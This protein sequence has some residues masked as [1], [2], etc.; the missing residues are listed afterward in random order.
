MKK[1]I[2][3]SAITGIL[4]GCGG[5]SGTL[6]ENVI[7]T[8]R[9]GASLTVIDAKTDAVKQTVAIPGSEPMYVVHVKQTDRLYVGDRAQNKVHV[10]HPST[11][12]IEASID[13]GRGVSHMWADAKGEQLWV[14]NDVDNTISVIKLS[15]RSVRTLSLQDKPH[16]V[17]LT[18]DGKTAYVS[19]L[20][21]NAPDKVLIFDAQ[22]LTQTSQVNVGEDPHLFFVE[23]DQKLYVANQEGGLNVFQRNLQPDYSL[24]L[25]GAHG[26]FASRSG[27]H[28]FMTNISGRQLYSLNTP[29]KALAEPALNLTV[30]TPH[31][32]VVNGDD[33]KLFVTHSGAA[34]NQV[35]VYNIDAQG[36]LSFSKAL[37]AGTNPFGIA[38]YSYW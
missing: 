15:D 25:A 10:L 2:L 20:V 7:V 36:K 11:F 30:N 27:T 22:T 33:K 28:V 35:T 16:D 21:P 19:L 9:G 32:L 38:Y 5:G 13:V 4:Y 3:L 18:A 31:N 6:T 17:F 8:N 26:I 34:A 24:D 12:N 23:Q 1:L 14:A 29:S 37:T